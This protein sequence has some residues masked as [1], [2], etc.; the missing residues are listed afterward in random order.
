MSLFL[1]LIL[2]SNNVNIHISAHTYRVPLVLKINIKLFYSR[3]Q[4]SAITPYEV[5]TCNFYHVCYPELGRRKRTLKRQNASRPGN[6]KGLF[7][8]SPYPPPPSPTPYGVLHLFSEMNSYTEHTLLALPWNQK[9]SQPTEGVS[10]PLI[11]EQL[12]IKRK[13]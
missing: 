11:K 13:L 1:S 12:Q 3:N 4:D 5:I 2:F 7:S 10:G 8:H 9:H 6:V